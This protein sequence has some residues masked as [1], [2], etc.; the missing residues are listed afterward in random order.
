[1]ICTLV[2]PSPGFK[3]P[4][5][6]NLGVTNDE[7]EVIDLSDNEI[8]RIENLPLLKHLTTL[9]LS[10]NK[11]N[12]IAVEL[13]RNAPAMES[14]VSDVHN[15][16]WEKSHA[17]FRRLLMLTLFAGI[18]H[19][20][21]FRQILTN[22]RL[23]SLSSLDPLACLTSLRTLSLLQ[24]PVCSVTDY[25]LYVIHLLPK[26]V[27]LDF[28]RVKPKEREAAVAKFGAAP[29]AASLA[30]AA[31]AAA[32]SSAP[33]QVEKVAPGQAVP[34]GQLISL[35]AS[36]ASGPPRLTPDALAA[37]KKRL[38]GLIQASSNLEEVNALQKQLEALIA[39]HA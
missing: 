11:I 37:E 9:L 5:I 4:H 19:H 17:T 10:N 29:T 22:N 25:R 1:L 12:K 33:M 16:K 39:R 28:N 35:N 23:S 31:A 14:L 34:T 7:Y 36:S 18:L 26:L 15:S 38:V 2:L 27:V 6:E 30:A 24:N 20:F 13:N 32:S 3:I 8:T 21:H